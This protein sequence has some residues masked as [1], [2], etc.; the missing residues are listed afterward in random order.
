MPLLPTIT[1]AAY[2]RY[3]VSRDHQS[4][5]PLP[6]ASDLVVLECWS[7]D[8]RVHPSDSDRAYA[9]SVTIL[10]VSAVIC[11][12]LHAGLIDKVVNIPR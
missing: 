4:Q 1:L 3:N 5:N 12:L 7:Y 2:T 9:F 10:V 6:L 11:Y 8:S